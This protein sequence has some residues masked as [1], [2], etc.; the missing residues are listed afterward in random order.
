METIQYYLALFR[1]EMMNEILNAPTDE[2]SIEYLSDR[3][4]ET[5]ATVFKYGNKRQKVIHP[6]IK[7]TVLIAVSMVIFF[8]FL[9][10]L[11]IV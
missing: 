3:L 11:S 9:I 7:M 5:Y 1:D 8:I 6:F 10:L 4:K 2:I